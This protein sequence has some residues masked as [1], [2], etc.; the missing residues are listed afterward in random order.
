[1]IL[2][3]FGANLPGQF[4]GPEDMFEVFCDR[5]AGYGLPIVAASDLW[6]TAPVPVSD[7]PDYY[8]AVVAVETE[9]SAHEVLMTLL[10]IEVDFGRKRMDVNAARTI[11]LD[12]IAY[13]DA[14]MVQDDLQVPHPR[15][16][17]RGF[18]LYPLQQVAP[19]W[20]HPVSGLP[21]GEMIDALPEA[22]KIGG[23]G[24]RKAA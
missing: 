24:I 19:D 7:Q 17:E 12:L 18:V 13:N 3:A 4:G 20:R 9:M 10:C 5:A 21:V 8:N 6:R 1:M 23:S 16:H 15:M 11:D 14:H 22:Q 2:I